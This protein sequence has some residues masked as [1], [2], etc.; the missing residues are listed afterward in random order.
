MGQVAPRPSFSLP[1]IPNSV[2][3]G[4]VRTYLEKVI[5][6]VT[7]ELQQRPPKYEARNEILMLTPDMTKTYSITISNTGV[8]TSTLVKNNT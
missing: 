8:L 7:Q 3:A 5:L 1:A 6:Q 4:E 2:K